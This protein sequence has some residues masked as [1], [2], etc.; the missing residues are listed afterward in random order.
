MPCRCAGTDAGGA[1]GREAL[2]AGMGAS[3]ASGTVAKK[4]IHAIERVAIGFTTFISTKEETG[5][6]MPARATGVSRSWPSRRARGLSC[7]GITSQILTGAAPY[8]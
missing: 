2:D 4:I 8:I 6:P 7:T 1:I 3:G 5:L